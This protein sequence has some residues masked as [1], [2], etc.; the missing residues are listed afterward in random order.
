MI[1]KVTKE[2]IDSA[3]KEGSSTTTIT[4]I[5]CCCPI[6]Q[7][8]HKHFANVVVGLGTARINGIAIKL[9]SKAKHITHLYMSE[10]AS[11]IPFEF[12]INSNLLK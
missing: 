1:I 10:W 2:C 4:S 12:H 8:L 9:P 5:A 7:A 3:I 11:I 6:Y